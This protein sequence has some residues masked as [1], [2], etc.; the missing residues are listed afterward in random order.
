MRVLY[1]DKIVRDGITVTDATE[2]RISNRW[3]AHRLGPSTRCE[4]HDRTASAIARA[5]MFERRGAAH[6]L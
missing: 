3:W 6:G 2:V 5:I 1:S 4:T